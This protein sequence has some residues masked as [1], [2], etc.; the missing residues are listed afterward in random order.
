MKK[1]LLMTILLF[2][3]AG[4]CWA[5]GSIRLSIDS[6]EERNEVFRLLIVRTKSFFDSS[7]EEKFFPNKI[8]EFCL[9]VKKNGLFNPDANAILLAVMGY[10]AESGRTIL[11]TCIC[12]AS[13][14]LGIPN[15]MDEPIPQDAF[16]LEYLVDANLKRDGF[17][18]LSN[19]GRAVLARWDT[20]FLNELLEELLI[21]KSSKDKGKSVEEMR[22]I[23][24]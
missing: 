1:V 5:Q 10:Q 11:E 19:G 21:Y 23:W 2:V 13:A 24:E 18:G 6:E 4:A 8:D 15:I 9:E 22:N 12:R 20:F 3:F 17:G 14:L 7:N 16:C